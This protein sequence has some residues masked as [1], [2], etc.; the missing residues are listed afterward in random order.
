MIETTTNIFQYILDL[1]KNNKVLVVT[2]TNVNKQYGYYLK[3]IP[4]LVL[5]FNYDSKDLKT[6]DKILSYVS[7]NKFNKNQSILIG[8]GTG[9]LLNLVG[10]TA[11][12]YLNGIRYIY[13]PT[14][15]L[16]MLK[17]STDNYNTLNSKESV[18][19]L[20][21]FN[22]PDK[23]IHDFRFIQN[24]DSEQF[25]YG[26][27]YIL[28]VAL[29]FSSDIWN[30]LKIH[31]LGYFQQN[32][33][34]L[35]ELIKVIIETKINK[36]NMNNRDLN[37]ERMYFSFGELIGNSIDMVLNKPSGHYLGL[38]ILKE[39]EFGNLSYEHINEI[40][41]IFQNYKIDIE[42]NN[43]SNQLILNHIKKY[44][45]QEYF[46]T[47]EQISK[48]KLVSYNF[49]DLEKIFNLEKE[50][51]Y[52]PN[53]YQ[54]VEFVAPS[55]KSETN[56]L[57]IIYALT[58][59][60]YTLKNILLSDDTK[61]MIQAL[62][63]LGVSLILDHNDITITGNLGN[64]KSKSDIY[65]GNSGTCMRFLISL[66][67]FHCQNDCIITG[68]NRMKKRHIN[69][70]VNSLLEFGVK[71]DYLENKGYPP[72]KIHG[73]VEDTGKDIKINTIKSSQF[74]SGL[75]MALPSYRDI[76]LTINSDIV[77]YTF[78]ELTLNLIRK[79]GVKIEQDKNNY[80]IT[81]SKYVLKNNYYVS[82]DA[83]ACI[84]PIIAGI[85]TQKK[86]K[87]LNLNSTNLQGDLKHC[88]QTIRNLG[89]EVKIDN[90]SYYINPLNKK[91]ST[92]TNLDL[93]SSDTFLT[94]CILLPFLSKKV[95]MFN[96]EN[97]NIKESNR[98]D[99]TYEYMKNMGFN[100]EK[101][102][103]NLIINSLQNFNLDGIYVDCH[104]DHRIAM[105]FAL[106]ASKMDNIVLSN[107]KCV[108][109]TYPKFWDDICK[110][111][112]YLK[113][114]NQ[115]KY[116]EKRKPYV[117]IGLPAS[118]KTTLVNSLQKYKSYDTDLLFE[119]KFQ[120]TPEEYILKN[121]FDDFRNKEL[122]ILKE[123]IK[124]KRL[125][126]VSTGGG[127]IEHNNF[128][129]VVKK[130]TVIYIDRNI[131][132]IIE[133]FNKRNSKHLDINQIIKERNYLQYADFYF[134]NQTI[135]NLYF[136]RWLNGLNQKINI[137]FNSYFLCL[138]LESIQ[139]HI[140]KIKQAAIDVNAIEVRVDLFKSYDLKFIGQ[141]VHFLK[142]H[143]DKPIIYTVRTVLEG[144]K[145]KGDPRQLLEF[146]YKLGCE[147]IDV[148]F[149]Y[150]ICFPSI[151]TIGSSHGNKF[152][153]YIVGNYNS[154][155]PDIIK[156]VTKLE[157]K[158][159]LEKLL[160][161]Y[162]NDKKIILYTGNKG[163]I[164]RV[165]NNFL[166]PVSC[167]EF[168]KTFP[169]QLTYYEIAT[170]KKILN[171]P[172]NVRC[173]LFGRYL[174]PYPI[175]KLHN[176]NFKRLN[177]NGL[178]NNYEKINISLTIEYIKSNKIVN[179]SICSPYKEVIV[180]YLD[181]ITNETAYIESVNNIIL[182]DNLLYGYNTDWKAII[183]VLEQVNP[184]SVILLGSGGTAQGIAYGL[185]KQKIQ[186]KVYSRN[187]DSRNK[188]NKKYGV[189]TFNLKDSYK[190]DL[191]INC[192]PKELKFNYEGLILDIHQPNNLLAQSFFR[193]QAEEDFKLWFS[194]QESFYHEFK[195]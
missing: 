71:I 141:E 107:Y 173:G 176:F 109:K 18:N 81:K 162:K 188:L 14:D 41:Q 183:K 16:S 51:Y 116:I 48:P 9:N 73:K 190:A 134:Y 66:I 15:L 28:K 138:N 185:H 31:N 150:P 156:V 172:I 158:N 37:Q 80:M 102:D 161:N 132:N 62:Q 79:F 182:K 139:P 12:I 38:G 42:I 191:I 179:S 100:I 65:I 26:M 120:I 89:Y 87:I 20:G 101:K 180:P 143:I 97:Q 171:Y 168:G 76:K 84:Y 39:L 96:I 128:K 13:V 47:L 194:I 178:M 119:E 2:N 133:D 164:S 136:E 174:K 154:V 60:T 170:I 93:D 82:A 86:V 140:K 163:V 8:F 124:N 114:P 24:L 83:T 149:R 165:E 91:D 32:F 52:V 21:F 45:L 181:V 30:Y 187:I 5:D 186:F 122:F 118:G 58:N 35:K 152:Y 17:N 108:E 27:I 6:V 57:L 153:D 68:D 75:L 117:L 46:V 126:V 113:E 90:D 131:D 61:Y 104:N 193:F 88:T 135:D 169:E 167:K 92:F 121:G 106:L 142:Q 3:N 137:P 125:D 59:K 56:R 11:S 115:N 34:K 157:N 148:E 85:L 50:V 63:Q 43:E 103:N 74:V 147:I 105:T 144:G 146:G 160:N 177:Y 33:S 40:K 29:L 49:K 94:I 54:E 64:F 55:S 129:K 175:S 77:S 110:F 69:D 23:I 189:F 7:E 78:I 192:L 151:T 127:I 1:S 145:Y 22:R 53:D 159:K 166:T 70:L 195:Y 19:T 130:N 67:A 44:N 25:S 98:I 95:T 111:G 123:F 155:K 72:I 36:L 99:I 184:K 112:I 4:K 10:F